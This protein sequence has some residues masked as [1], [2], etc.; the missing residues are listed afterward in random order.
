M[1]GCGFVLFGF[2]WRGCWFLFDFCF[3]GSVFLDTASVEVQITCFLESQSD[4]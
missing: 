4:T 1:V 3:G 2:F